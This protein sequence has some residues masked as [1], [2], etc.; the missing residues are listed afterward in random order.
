M[1]GL[2][3]PNIEVD[4]GLWVDL[5]IYALTRQLSFSQEFVFT[6]GYC[7]DCVTHYQERMSAYRLPNVE[8]QCNAERFKL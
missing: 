7:P 3:D 1:E 2:D 4:K 5:N 6:H 8:E